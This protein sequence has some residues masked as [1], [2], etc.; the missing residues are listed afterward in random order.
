VTKNESPFDF[1]YASHV[2]EH[3]PNPVG[4][5][6]QVA[7]VL[8]VGGKVSLVIPDKRFCFDVNRQAT[9][10]ADLVDAYLSGRAHPSLRSICDFHSRIVAV[11]TLGLWSGEAD[12]SGVWREDREPDFW[13][14]ELCLI[15]R[16]CVRTPSWLL[17]AA[18]STQSQS[19]TRGSPGTEERPGVGPAL[20]GQGAA[21]DL[22]CQQGLGD[23][24]QR[25]VG[26][27][28]DQVVGPTADLLVLQE[29]VEPEHSGCHPAG[30]SRSRLDRQT[31]QAQE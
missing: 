9:E 16:P 31:P 8:E 21:E 23:Q 25:D 10:I 17:P 3:L 6:E 27:L 12:Y 15:G 1:V 28:A 2:F 26:A 11:D 7:D 29:L 13:A 18:R 19:P 20:R 30:Q 5:L 24:A 4:W 14:Y 22:P